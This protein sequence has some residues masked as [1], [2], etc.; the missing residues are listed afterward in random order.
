[1]RGLVR[2]LRNTQLALTEKLRSVFDLESSGRVILYSALV[3]VVA[4]LGAAGFF[5]VLDLLKEFA[6]GHV[7]GYYPP[8]AG[9]EPIGHMPQFPEHWWAVLLVPTVVTFGAA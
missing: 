5:F 6:L 2:R 7:E 4:G 8:A 3:G 9:S 1:M